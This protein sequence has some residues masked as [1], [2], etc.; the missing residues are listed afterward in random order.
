MLMPP[1]AAANKAYN[2]V[3]SGALSAATGLTARQL[4]DPHRWARAVVQPPS[5][6]FRARLWCENRA[7]RHPVL[8]ATTQRR[9]TAAGGPGLAVSAV[10]DG[11]ESSAAWFDLS[12]RYRNRGCDIATG[13]VLWIHEGDR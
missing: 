13:I 9:A 4:H 3:Y 8:R 12:T 1:A 11:V 10:V 2:R 6:L 5:R 7:D